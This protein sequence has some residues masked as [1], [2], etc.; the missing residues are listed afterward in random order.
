LLSFQNCTFVM[1]IALADFTEDALFR[2]IDEELKQ[3][4]AIKIWKTYKL[5]IITAVFLPVAIVVGYQSWQSWAL[6]ERIELS[7]RYYKATKLLED[8]PTKAND[9]LL[10][11]AQDRHMGYKLLSKFQTAA[12][13]AKNKNEV[14]AMQVYEGLAND[15][16]ISK[17]YR[18][19]ASLLYIIQSIDL[20]VKTDSAIIDELSTLTSK[21]NPW[22]Y[23][24]LELKALLSKKIGKTNEA[25]EIY[26][27]L[28][29]DPKTSSG[30]RQRS[31]AIMLTLQN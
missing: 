11:L 28:L 7:E 22:R 5:Y 24:A 4:R 20:G 23:T 1:E 17:I 25:K 30:I 19:L 6:T 13:L 26:Q 2:E 3:D 10:R 15:K 31:Q 18:D 14:A 12:T 29:V 16:K 9:M 21:E 8:S 27:K